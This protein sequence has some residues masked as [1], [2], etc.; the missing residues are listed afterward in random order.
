MI[1]TVLF[2]LDGT[3]VDSSADI[4]GSLHLA[5]QHSGYTEKIDM[6][7]TILGPPVSEMIR[8]LTPE[9][10]FETSNLITS[11]FRAIYDSSLYPG[12]YMYEG[13]A[14]LLAECAG[15][16][17]T[18]CIVTNKLK[19]ATT[20]LLSILKIDHF[21]TQ[22][23]T[24]DCLP[25][26]RMNKNEMVSYVL[27]HNGFSADSTILIGDSASDIEA[28]H[29]NGIRS[30]GFSGGFGDVRMLIDAKPTF[31]IDAF[32]GLNDTLDRL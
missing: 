22:V 20:R 19:Y 3:I 28:A 18:M 2:D 16:G 30:L 12:S 23:V 10:P 6:P 7:K 8:I 5:Y 29:S 13:V 11:R 4:I 1:C 25:E 26:R 31:L 17:R 14:D 15:S 24:P 21:F 27:Q 9:L 32:N